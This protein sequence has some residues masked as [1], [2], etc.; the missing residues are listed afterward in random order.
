[1]KSGLTSTLNEKGV[2]EHFHEAVTEELMI[3]TVAYFLFIDLRTLTNEPGEPSKPKLHVRCG[4]G[5]CWWDDC[6]QWSIAGSVPDYGR[7][8]LAKNGILLHSVLTN[9]IDKVS[10]G[11]KNRGY[12]HVGVIDLL[13]SRGSLDSQ[14]PF[15]YSVALGP[16][17][18]FLHALFSSND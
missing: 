3:F 13:F 10:T 9:Y 4:G 16:I 14:H 8:S 7:G 5:E 18:S 11:D 17:A 6:G 15:S 2:S 12:G 1:M